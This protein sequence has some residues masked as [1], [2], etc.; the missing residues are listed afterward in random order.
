MRPAPAAPSWRVLPALKIPDHRPG[1]QHS[2]VAFS[3]R[4][5]M[6]GVQDRIRRGICPRVRL[7]REIGYENQL[8][9]IAQNPVCGQCPC[10]ELTAVFAFCR[11]FVMSR[12]QLALAYFE[13]FTMEVKPNGAY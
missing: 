13:Q 9:A 2:A 7:V 12:I 11:E 3:G 8:G 5:G 4:G 1:R 6:R 10:A